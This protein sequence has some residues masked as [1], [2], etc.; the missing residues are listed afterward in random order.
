M[1]LAIDLDT[2]PVLKDFIRTSPAQ[3]KEFMGMLLDATNDLVAMGFPMD[4]VQETSKQLGLRP[5]D[6]FAGCIAGCLNEQLMNEQM[7]GI[8]GKD[9]LPVAILTLKGLTLDGDEM[10]SDWRRWFGLSQYSTLNAD[11][12]AKVIAGIMK[13]ARFLDFSKFSEAIESNSLIAFKGLAH[14]QVKLL[15]FI[16]A[17]RYQREVFGDFKVGKFFTDRQTGFFDCGEIDAIEDNC[18]ACGR[19]DL[20]VTRSKKHKYCKACNA[21]YILKNT[22]VTF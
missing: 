10:Y 9:I 14:E 2:R 5:A 15:P 12:I 18:L 19:E 20:Q 16:P 4:I 6:L 7:A 11:T 3:A 21:G 22:E 1:K 13:Y 8:L 17:L